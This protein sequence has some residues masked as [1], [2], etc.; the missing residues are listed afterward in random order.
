MEDFSKLCD[1]ISIFKLTLFEGNSDKLILNKLSAYFVPELIFE[2][3][4]YLQSKKRKITGT[5]DNIWT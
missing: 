4:A 3:L 1:L 2:R 5:E